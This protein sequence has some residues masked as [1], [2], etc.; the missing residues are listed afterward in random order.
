[1]ILEKKSSNSWG[2]FVSRNTAEVVIPLPA[3][4]LLSKLT[5]VVER[6]EVP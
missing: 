5:T 3:H 1:M 2:S 6:V 4:L